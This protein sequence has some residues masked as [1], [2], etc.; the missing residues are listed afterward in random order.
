MKIKIH[1]ATFAA[2][3]KAGFSYAGETTVRTMVDEIS[4]DYKAA[5][6]DLLVVF[7]TNDRAF[8]YWTSSDLN[9]QVPSSPRKPAYSKTQA[10]KDLG[11]VRGKDSTGRTIWE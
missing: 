10:M 9:K 6:P 8:Q 2:M 11:L 4:R 3:F 7:T 5:N 1:K